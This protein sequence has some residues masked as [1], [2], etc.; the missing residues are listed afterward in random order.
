MATFSNWVSGATVAFFSESMAV[1]RS[2]V[3]SFTPGWASNHPSTEEM[4][5]NSSGVAAAWL[6]KA[7]K[8][9][10]SSNAP[11]EILLVRCHDEPV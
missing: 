7:K 3:R 2:G 5:I 4:V 9:S 8:A 11:F 6:A 1:Y 10:S